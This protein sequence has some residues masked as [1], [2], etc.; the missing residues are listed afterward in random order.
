MVNSS[1]VRVM[2]PS[3]SFLFA[4]LGASLDTS[5]AF[6]PLIKNFIFEGCGLGVV[7]GELFPVLNQ[8]VNWFGG[9]IEER[10]RMSEVRSSELETGLSSND[11]LMEEDTTISSP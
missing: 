6:I 7:V 5:G 8:S 10:K 1:K 11:G 2:C 9:L 4:H 3:V